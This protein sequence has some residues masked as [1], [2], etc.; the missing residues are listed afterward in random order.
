MIKILIATVATTLAVSAYA[1]DREKSTEYKES[2]TTNPITGSTTTT[3]KT[4]HKAKDG[5]HTQKTE[6]KEKVKRHSDGST[7]HETKSKTT[8]DLND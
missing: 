6:N 7:E 1:D 5:S 4:E 2:T 8:N 3:K